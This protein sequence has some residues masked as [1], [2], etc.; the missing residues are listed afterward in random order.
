MRKKILMIHATQFGYHN[1]AFK[2][3]TVLSKDYDITFIC[4]KQPSNKIITYD[5]INV[6]YINWRKPILFSKVLFMLYCIYRIF[7]FYG[8]IFVYYFPGCDMFKKL[9]RKKIMI[10]DVR[11]LG[12]SSD[13]EY[14]RKHDKNLLKTGLLYNH[15]CF[16]SEAIRKKINFPKNKSTIVDLGAD[17]ISTK[18]KDYSKFSLLYVGTLNNRNLDTTIRGIKLYIDETLDRNLEYHIVGGGTSDVYNKLFNLTKDLGLSDIIKFYGSIP[19]DEISSYFDNCSYGIS[20]VPMTDYY[21]SQP[22]TKTIEYALSGL[23]VIGTATS[24]NGRMI[25]DENGILIQDT[26]DSFSKAIYFVKNNYFKFKENS[27]RDSLKQFLWEN[28]ISN[29]LIPLIRNII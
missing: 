13:A 29:E 16:L 20:F 5:Q 27:I 18:N 24:E 1:N 9:F 21:D 15:V 11:T 17:V 2:H 4:F 28:I 26:P 3:S 14:N 19:H 6:K 10:L 12:V 22:V 23:F 25:N 8:L 7:F